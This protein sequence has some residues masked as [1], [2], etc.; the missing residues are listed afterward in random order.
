MMIYTFECLY[1]DA[2]MDSDD[3]GDGRDG[4]S[5]PDEEPVKRGRKRRTDEEILADIRRQ[6]RQLAEKE[7]DVG[8]RIRTKHR[9]RDTRRKIQMGSFILHRLG[10]EPGRFA[11]LRAVLR[12]ELPG[13]LKPADRDLFPDILDRTQDAGAV[14][15]PTVGEILER[16]GAE[17][18]R[19]TY[20]AVAGVLGITPAQVGPLL[21]ERTPET[22]WVVSA[23]TGRPAG[24][25]PEQ[26]HPDLELHPEVIGD[27]EELRA[28]CRHGG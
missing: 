2:G 4:E 11:E 26:V 24:Y 14:P 3:T 1:G 10:T 21:G 8:K 9:A 12:D 20:G 7:R 17:R 25:S 22:S 18:R 16:L 23:K 28:L 5:L 6:Q 13:F 27:P 19:C 15:A